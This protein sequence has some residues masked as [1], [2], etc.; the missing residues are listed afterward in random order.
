MISQWSF[1]LPEPPSQ[2]RAQM[3]REH[4]VVW[5]LTFRVFTQICIWRHVTFVLSHFFFLNHL[6]LIWKQRGDNNL[7]YFCRGGYVFTPGLDLFVC[8]FFTTQLGGRMCY[9]S[10]KRQRLNFVRI[11]IFFS[12]LSLKLCC[13]INWKIPVALFKLTNFHTWCEQI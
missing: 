7:N 11:R 9:G 13:C 10:G 6:I 3:K 4:L 12:P 1:I 8:L 5:T 2:N